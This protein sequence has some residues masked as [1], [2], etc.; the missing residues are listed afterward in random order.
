MNAMGYQY[1]W[2]LGMP[3]G[4]ILMSVLPEFTFPEW[5]R[6]A[7][8]EKATELFHELAGEEN[9][10][11]ASEILARLIFDPLMRSTR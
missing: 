3:R 7:V 2:C 4:E 6:P 5:L 9:N 11:E 10:T 8:R 1:G